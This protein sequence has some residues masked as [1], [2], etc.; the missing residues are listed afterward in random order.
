MHLFILTV[1]SFLSFT[2]VPNPTYYFTGLLIFAETDKIVFL[3]CIITVEQFHILLYLAMLY[4]CKWYRCVS[5]VT[6]KVSR[7]TNKSPIHIYFL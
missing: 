4:A 3:F 7:D 5:H 2:I 1:F 6:L